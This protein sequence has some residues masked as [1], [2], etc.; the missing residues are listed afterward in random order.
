VSTP[1]GTPTRGRQ[2]TELEGFGL[3]RLEALASGLPVAATSVGGT[4]EILS[5][6]DEKCDLS[7]R[8]TNRETGTVLAA[9]L[10]S[11]YHPVGSRNHH[12]QI[13]MK[14]AVPSHPDARP[15]GE[16]LVVD[17]TEWV[18]GVD[19][20][21][22]LR[23]DGQ[24]AYLERYVRCVLCGAERMTERDFPEECPG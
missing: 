7:V 5:A 21:R 6:L 23:Y 9:T 20:D 4:V 8:A 22:Y 14:T 10:V 3:A 19:P 15:V 17:K 1:T 2:T 13:S 18:P 12:P 16:H 11:Q 24:R